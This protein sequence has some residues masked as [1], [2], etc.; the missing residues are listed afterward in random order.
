MKNLN[1]KLV[2]IAMVLAGLTLEQGYAQIEMRDRPTD[3]KEFAEYIEYLV[4]VA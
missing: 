1:S 2:L 3:E 4:E